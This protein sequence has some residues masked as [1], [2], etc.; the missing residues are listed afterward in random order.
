M[1]AY[2]LC[3]G[4]WCKFLEGGILSLSPPPPLPLWIFQN[5]VHA[6]TNVWVRGHLRPCKDF[7]EVELCLQF[8]Y[9]F[10]NPKSKIWIMGFKY[11]TF[12][13]ISCLYVW[14]LCQNLHP[15][16]YLIFQSFVFVIRPFDLL[17]RRTKWKW[18]EKCFYTCLST[19]Q[20]ATNWWQPCKLK[21]KTLKTPLKLI[22]FFFEINMGL[23]LNIKYPKLFQWK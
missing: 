1:C 2:P 21:V 6:I 11:V 8:K 5:L 14:Q 7:K 18:L 12:S 10:D 15:N 19:N 23:A 20:E 13:M 16:K 9:G 17:K 22:N 3:G 4:I